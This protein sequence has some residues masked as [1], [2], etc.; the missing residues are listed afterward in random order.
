MG[1]QAQNTFNKG[2]L[3]AGVGIGVAN[4]AGAWTSFFPSVSVEYGIIDDLFNDK[5]SLGVGGLFGFGMSKWNNDIIIGLRGAL[6]YQFIDKLDTYGGLML[7]AD[8]MSWKKGY[9]LEGVKGK[10]AGFF[11][12][13]PY[14]GARYYLMDQLAG[15]AE[16]GFG[17][18]LNAYFQVGVAYK[19]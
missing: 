13:A 7:G 1:L 6:H 9:Y 5:S 11:I 19:F 18:S 12:V 8:I 3:V 4:A 2:D 15:F 10:S 17:A 14:F 16:F